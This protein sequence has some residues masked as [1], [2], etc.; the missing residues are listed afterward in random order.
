M[1]DDRY[2]KN[3]R[4]I[5]SL[6][7]WVR[8]DVIH[9]SNFNFMLAKLEPFVKDMIQQDEENKKI[10][11]ETAKYIQQNSSNNESSSSNK[12]SFADKDRRRKEPRSRKRY[13]ASGWTYS[14]GGNKNIQYDSE[15][16]NDGL[17]SNN[18]DGSK[19]DDIDIPD[20]KVQLDEK[21]VLPKLGSFTGP[22]NCSEFFSKNSK[23][24]KLQVKAQSHSMDN[25]RENTD[26]HLT[27][28]K[29]GQ[30]PSARLASLAAFA[31][32]KGDVRQNLL[33]S[34]SINAL[35]TNSSTTTLE[36]QKSAINATKVPSN[37]QLNSNIPSNVDLQPKISTNSN[38]YSAF[39]TPLTDITSTNCS[40]VTNTNPNKKKFKF[41]PALKDSAVRTSNDN[42]MSKNSESVQIS[43]RYIPGNYST[44][45]TA[46]S[47]D[48]FQ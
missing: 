48:D 40:N 11:K 20:P 29:D 5:N 37:V 21:R 25:P 42:C 28:T 38:K 45:Y 6:S 1:V 18:G 9:H 16:S 39:S 26:N 33:T 36:C 4:Y 46:D 27:R 22:K 12:Q 17:S 3:Q 35:T 24:A 47:D 30:S 44:S 8:S 31:V 13:A 14:K 7:K 41:S 34:P 19:K 10:E 32:H 15:N 23:Q 2:S 43:K